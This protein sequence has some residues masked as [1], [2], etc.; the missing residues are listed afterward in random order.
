V[1]ATQF[2]DAESG[3]EHLDVLHS[4]EVNGV[5]FVEETAAAV[6][7]LATAGNDDI[8]KGAFDEDTD[9]VG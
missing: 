2:H 3:D 4:V 1:H 6:E 8:N 7:L 5:T 9:A